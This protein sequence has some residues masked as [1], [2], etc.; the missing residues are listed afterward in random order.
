MNWTKT[1]PTKPG[2]YAWRINSKDT[3][4]SCRE[5]FSPCKDVL[6]ERSTDWQPKDCGGEWCGPLVPVEEVELIRDVLTSTHDDD[7]V[8]MN[9]DREGMPPCDCGYYEK[10]ERARKIVEGEL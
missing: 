7:C 6:I 5:V 4:V 2:F 8:T 3:R 9:E 10:W 1:P